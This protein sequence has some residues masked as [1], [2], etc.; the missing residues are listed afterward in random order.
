MTGLNWVDYSI[1]SVFAVSIMA[2]LMRGLVREVI[3]IVSWFAAVVV[4]SMF[5]S[6]LAATFTSDPSVQS[7]LTDA[8]TSMGV[9]A[10]QPVSYFAIGISFV[11]LFVGTLI[12]G[13][14]INYFLSRAAEFQGISF[15]NRALGAVFGF[16]RGF[17]L[18][19]V[20]M[21]LIQLS[22]LGQQ[23]FWKQSQFV[24]SF[25]PAIVWLANV[26]QPGLEGIKAKMDQTLQNVGSQV[27]G[28]VGNFAP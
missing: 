27:Q 23:A 11:I 8:S 16:A 19:L 7:A 28:A 25:Q 26:V 6:R 3:S 14:L 20:I 2:G 21:F 10:A 4:A 22:P 12:I 17:L 1:V 13:S 9:N 15:V 18:N 24:Q 5:S